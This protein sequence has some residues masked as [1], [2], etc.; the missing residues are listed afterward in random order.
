MEKAPRPVA[1]RWRPIVTGS[2]V[3]LAAFILAGCS[4][5]QKLA[6]LAGVEP[7]ERVVGPHDPVPPGG[8]RY[9]VGRAYSIGGRTYVPRE[10]PNYDATGVASWYGGEYHHG[11]RTAN[12]EVYDRTT[13]SAAH[14]TMPLPSYARVTNIRNGR[15]IIVRVNDRGPYAANRLIDISEKT[16]ELL[17]MKRGGVGNVRVQYVGRA[18][19]AGSDQRVLAATLHGP[20]IVQQDER[21]LLAMADLP[22]GPRRNLPATAAPTLIAEAEAPVPAAPAGNV[23]SAKPTPRPPTLALAAPPAQSDARAFE[24]AGVDAQ[25]MRALIAANT[26][27][28]ET[29]GEVIAASLPA[30]SG[31]P[32]SIL[33]PEPVALVAPSA[34]AGMLYPMPI[35]APRTSFVDETAA[36]TRI[37]AAHAIFASVEGGARFSDLAASERPIR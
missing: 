14:P 13:L 17:D 29:S 35:P 2:S 31:G 33:P 27:P 1:I 22:A 15:S 36:E 5:T 28:A 24:L 9:Q 26:R 12:G 7:L 25:A 3:V 16:A 4:A 8:G 20:G 10:D 21:R 19:L 18:G 23:F 11:T 30:A 34:T 32:M 6:S 37:A